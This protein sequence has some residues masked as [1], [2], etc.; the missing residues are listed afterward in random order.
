MEEDLG[1]NS[2]GSLVKSYEHQFLREQQTD[3]LFGMMLWL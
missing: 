3:A 1:G 2:G